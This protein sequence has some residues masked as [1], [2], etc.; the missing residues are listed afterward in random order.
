MEAVGRRP[1]AWVAA[2]VLLAEAL[3]VVFVNGVLATVVRNQQM[4]LAGLDP[5]AMSAGTWAMGGV[6][7]LYLV[8]C[9]AL[10]V[11][12]AVKDLAPGR[13][14]RVVLIACAVVHGVLGAVTVG[15]V[16]WTAFAF[17]MVVLALIVLILVAYDRER[18][19]G[20][21]DEEP[22]AGPASGSAEGPAPA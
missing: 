7:G 6:F 16:G 21:R 8:L 15:L 3:G 2:I 17:M 4:S 13:F 20:H 10:L 5:D 9:A 1:V 14:G 11:R 19:P 18:R 12:T 22:A